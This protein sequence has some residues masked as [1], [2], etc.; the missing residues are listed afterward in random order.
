MQRHHFNTPNLPAI[1]GLGSLAGNPKG[2]SANVWEPVQTI[3]A[4]H[5]FRTAYVD[6][7]QMH[8][9]FTTGLQ[10]NTFVTYFGLSN[11]FSAVG[12]F[13]VSLKGIAILVYGFVFGKM[14]K[15]QF[16]QMLYRKNQVSADEVQEKEA[17]AE[18]EEKKGNDWENNAIDRTRKKQLKVLAK[19]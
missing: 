6:I 16:A 9:V 4:Q 7:A 12:G 5:D 13:L 8:L 19:I 3:L 18:E 11:V 14:I 1:F 17:E 2:L 10:K 15:R